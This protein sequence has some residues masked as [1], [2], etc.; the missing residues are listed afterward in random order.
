MT[1]ARHFSRFLKKLRQNPAQ[2]VLFNDQN[3]FLK[4][5]QLKKINF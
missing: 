4:K 1:D 5:T 3:T 2:E